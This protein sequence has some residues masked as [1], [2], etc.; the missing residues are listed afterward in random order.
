MTPD[1]SPRKSLGP[2]ALSAQILPKFK[3]PSYI[4]SNQSLDDNRSPGLAKQLT[5]A[6]HSSRMKL[7]S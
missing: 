2:L 5:S 4:D 7:H 3:S 1:D 6:R